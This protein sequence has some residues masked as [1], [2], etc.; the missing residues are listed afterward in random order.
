MNSRALF[1]SDAIDST[2]FNNIC[3][4][5]NADYGIDVGEAN[6]VNVNVPTHRNRR[7]SDAFNSEDV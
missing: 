1:Y 5:C 3:L 6:N 2:V 7:H 4:L